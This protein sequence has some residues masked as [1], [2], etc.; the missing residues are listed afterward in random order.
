MR[1]LILKH[2]LLF[3][4]FE[5]DHLCWKTF[6]FYM[7]PF[8]I[9]KRAGFKT[10]VLKSFFIWGWF[11]F[12]L[13]LF[14][15]PTLG[16]AQGYSW[17]SILKLLLGYSGIHTGYWGPNPERLHKKSVTLH[18]YDRFD[19]YLRM[20]LIPYSTQWYC[21]E[22]KNSWLEVVFLFSMMPSC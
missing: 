22:K 13:S 19:N 15:E 10:R 16:D 4:Y 11:H 17:L 12:V 6:A 2:L 20:F 3:I 8:S 1:L 18:F 14:R 9:L 7:K 21:T 5:F